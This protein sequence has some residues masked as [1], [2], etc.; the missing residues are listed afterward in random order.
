M[1]PKRRRSADKQAP[2]KPEE[3]KIESSATK[4]V[5][6]DELC[7]ILDAGAQYGKVID[8]RVRELRVH[9]DI[10]PLSTPA[11]DLT[12][13]KALI[14]SGG[15]QSVYGPEA[16]KYDTKL[17]NL[18]IPILGICYGL[19]LM[20][21]VHGGTVE[22]GAIRE[23]GQDEVTFDS[24]S[25]LFD[26]IEEGPVLLTHGDSC[27]KVATDFKVI[28][29]SSSGLIAAIE[30]KEKN[31]YATQFHPEVDL[32]TH[33]KRMLENFLFKIAKFTGTYTAKSREK[34]AISMIRK[35]AGEKKILV[36]VS[37]GVDSTVC[38][39]LLSKALKPDQVYA[40]H[41]DTGFM[42]YKESDLVCAA[43]A[44]VG[45]KNLRKVDAAKTFYEAKTMIDGKETEAL[46]DTLSPEVKRK[47]IGD[48]FMKVAEEAVK[49]WGLKF[50]D[51][52]LAQGTLRPDLIESASKIAS[53]N[54]TV[55]KTHHNDTAL[56][57]ALR[58]AGRVIEPLK[59]F[60]KDEVRVLGVELGLPEPLVWR[61]PF[62]GPGLAIR[63]IC[64]NEPWTTDYDKDILKALKDY[65]SA[66]ISATLLPC[67]TVGVQG[68]CRSY[69][70]LVALS[71]DDTVDWKSIITLAKQIPKKVHHVNRCIYVFGEKIKQACLTTITETYL[72]KDAI[73]QLQLADH[74]V[75]QVLE[76]HKLNRHLSQVPVIL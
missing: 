11:S 30:H 10:L 53:S 15:P 40:L 19:Q 16:P 57:R 9:S 8:R 26:G 17:F 46:Q 72:K 27:D 38:A 25:L 14:I 66:H 47:I 5:K 6:S 31:F 35:V 67:R 33:G 42:R 75:N 55:I 28:S 49:E 18:G 2:P 56:V 29:R 74:I 22:K 61:Q 37:G 1:P 71:C 65:N 59:D 20:N 36:L 73:E 48:T 64:L 60:H 44:E 45:I 13:Y 43:L 7:A 70:S 76:K 32:T 68:D 54:A 62:P 69:S 21:F 24:T 50:E 58:D 23:D 3:K 39:T 63:I 12:K 51:L 52:L 4:K 41:V 34:S